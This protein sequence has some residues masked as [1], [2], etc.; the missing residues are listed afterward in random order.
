MNRRSFAEIIQ[1][2]NDLFSR[3]VND[4]NLEFISKAYENNTQ[5]F[6]RPSKG[7]IEISI[8]DKEER[9]QQNLSLIHI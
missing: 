4:I 8:H 9:E 3:V 2:N 5:E 7:Y 6:H 1:F